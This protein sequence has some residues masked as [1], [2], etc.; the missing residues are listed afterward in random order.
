MY[1][2]A[3]AIATLIARDAVE[4]VDIYKEYIAIAVDKL[5]NLPRLASHRVR[6]CYKAIKATH[7]VVNMDNI[8]THTQSIKFCHGHLF[9]ALN[10][11][12]NLIT[13]IAVKYLMLSI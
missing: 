11:A 12:I 13:A 1:L 5:N 10:L 9:I 4:R 2:R 6:K 8:V 7:A 3:L